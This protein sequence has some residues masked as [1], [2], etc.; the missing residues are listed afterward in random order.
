MYEAL[1]VVVVAALLWDYGRRRLNSQAFRSD[2]LGQVAESYARELRTVETALDELAQ[3][4]RLVLSNFINSATDI[5][6]ISQEEKKHLINKVA[7]SKLPGK[8]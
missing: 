1:T 3:Y 7:M 2:Q 5:I 4:Q 6:T 8:I